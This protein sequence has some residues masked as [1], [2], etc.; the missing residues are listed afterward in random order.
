MRPTGTVCWLW[1]G[2]E[3]GSAFPLGYSRSKYRHGL[4]RPWVRKALTLLT[5][6]LLCSPRAYAQ[7]ADE[8]D[9]STRTLT[10]TVATE[11]S[12]EPLENVLVELESQGLQ[13]LTD[14]MGRFQIAG[15]RPGIDTVRASYF[16]LAQSR[17]PVDLTSPG[18]HR[19]ELTLSDAAFELAALVVRIDA[20]PREAR[21]LARRI[22]A[23][24]GHLISYDQ[25]RRWAPAR[26][27]DLFRFTSRTR[28]RCVYGSC[29]V[30]LRRLGGYCRPAVFVNERTAPSWVLETMWSDDVQAVEIYWDPWVPAEFYRALDQDDQVR[31]TDLLYDGSGL[32]R[33]PGMFNECGAINI[34][35]GRS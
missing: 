33:A 30:L 7:K 32:E 28:V 24:L 10:G 8:S 20:T 17:I 34:W 3:P 5:F 31:M 26:L 1:A 22:K 13:A 27:M 19:V 11:E 4:C 14:S 35:T 29:E 21:R 25:M 18:G 15:A 6:A 23:G 9:E 2:G 16:S 12:G